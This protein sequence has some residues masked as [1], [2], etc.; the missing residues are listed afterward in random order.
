M[1]QILLE[2]L[3]D[4]DPD[5][6]DTLLSD[7][8]KY[9]AWQ[10]LQDPVMTALTWQLVRNGKHPIMMTQTHPMIPHIQPIAPATAT[11]CAN[12]KPQ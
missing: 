3:K 5:I 1:K 6:R 7:D 8:G 11:T 10:Y 2:V 12:D 4:V 9:P